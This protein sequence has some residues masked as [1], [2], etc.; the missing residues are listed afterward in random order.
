M[1]FHNCVSHLRA[2]LL[3]YR[4]AYLLA[5]YGL[6]RISNLT[7]KSASGFDLSRHLLRIDVAFLY[8]GAHI[9]VKWARKNI[10]APEKV[11]VLRVPRIEGPFICPVTALQALHQKFRLK[12]HEPLFILDDYQLLTQAHLRIWL[13]TFLG[14]M[15][16]P[17]LGH[18]FHTFRRSTATIA[19][20][21]NASLTAIKLMRR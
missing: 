17:L 10:Q 11:H 20:D 4:C 6:F 3:T 21:A 19:Y 5:F 9:Q 15:G 1:R 7:P 14:I 18:G 12:P 2:H 8:T 13:A 16:V